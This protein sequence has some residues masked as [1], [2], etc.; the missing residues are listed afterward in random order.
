MRAHPHLYE[1][2]TWPWLERLSAE[3]G[4]RITL[5]TVPAAEWD[6]LRALG[7]DLV[8]LMGVWERS[9]IS[10]QIARSEPR[11]FEAYDRGL[12][13]WAP[14]DIVGS[15]Y[16]IRQYVPDPQLG[17]WHDLE[18]ARHA[19]N[20]SGMRLVLDFVPNHTGFD[21][22]WI[23][24]HPHRYVRATLEQF[25]KAPQ[26]FRVVEG[27]SDDGPAYVACGRDPFFPPWTDVAQL[28][29]FEMDTRE[30][31]VNELATIGE[32]C[33][34]VRCDMAMLLIDDVFARTWG[35]LVGR[36]DPPGEFWSEV[37]NELPDLMLIGEAYWDL[38]ARLQQLGFSYTYD[39]RLYDGIVA[40]DS[41]AVRNRLAADAD[42][43]RRCVR[44]LENHDEPRSYA[45]FGPS[46]IEAAAV[47]LATA[48]GMRMYYEGQLEGRK[49]YSPVQLRRWLEEA[50][51]PTLTVMYENLLDV[52][53]RPVFHEGTCQPL[54]V[55][56]AGDGSHGSLAALWWQRAA[57]F[58][59]VVT[60]LGDHRAQGLV[61]LP[62]SLPPG[63]API[64]FEE[65]LRSA[66]YLRDRTE[67]R[68]Q[69]LY[70]QLEAGRAHLFILNPS[71]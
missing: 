25:R 50:E 7:F 67:L 71:S 40:G 13:E 17:T 39:K 41:V 42:F 28:N 26:E 54:E 19:V 46:R 55:R 18:L 2:N 27:N 4:R 58:S 33:D 22:P 45:V 68:R 8:Y 48:P 11:L 23:T 3:S 12:P 52:S 64:V 49:R 65:Q 32:H 61:Q 6:R 29:Y 70:V 16:S 10:R 44:F 60:N 1:I 34:A 59:L 9:A 53:N 62:P 35:A 30:A 24:T 21:H 56:D 63:E 31:M 20:R 43:Q 69:G 66:T 5:G 47:T 14:Q 36:D 15:P 37:R 51:Q 38:E 57:D